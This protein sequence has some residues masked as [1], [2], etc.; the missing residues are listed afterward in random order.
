MKLPWDEPFGYLR[1]I[2]VPESNRSRIFSVSTFK[3]IFLEI[4]LIALFTIHFFK[5]V[6][7]PPYDLNEIIKQSYLIG[8]KS[9]S[10]VGLTAFI[11]GLVLTIQMKP[12][13]AEVGAEAWLPAMVAVSIIR[14]IGPAITALLCAGRVGSGIGAELAIMKTTEQI[15]A[16]K[17][18]GIN[19][20]KYVVVTRILA[21]ALM[22]PLLV[23]FADAASL[24]GSYLVVSLKGDVSFHLYVLQ[25]FQKLTFTDVLPAFIKTFFF[26]FAIGLIGCYQGYNAEEG[27]QGIGKAANSAVVMA[28]FMIFVID[29]VVVQ[30]SSFFV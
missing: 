25:V 6:L 30:I 8:Y 17:L 3:K 5:E 27:N 23:V 1:E 28:S 4:Y 18:A 13:L 11:M 9:L 2:G 12:T 15:D 22:I 24:S 29:I 14:E 7:R 19:P 21:A 16:M 26:G 20:F 10:L